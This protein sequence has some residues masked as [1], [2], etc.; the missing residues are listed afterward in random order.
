MSL[1]E[2]PHLV[3]KDFK[4]LE[5][6]PLVL[7]DLCHFAPFFVSALNR[8]EEKLHAGRGCRRAADGLGRDG[9]T[10]VSR[11]IYGAVKIF[12]PAAVRA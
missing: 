3:K 6:K 5:Q 9:G 4:L 12:D 1:S 10:R 8:K 2:L 11:R 7:L